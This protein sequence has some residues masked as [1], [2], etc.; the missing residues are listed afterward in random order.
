MDG[1]CAEMAAVQRHAQDVNLNARTSG[2]VTGAHVLARDDLKG[3]I[4]DQGHRDGR[5]AQ[6]PLVLLVHRECCNGYGEWLVKKSL[7]KHKWL[8]SGNHVARMLEN[9]IV[10]ITFTWTEPLAGQSL[11]YDKKE[12]LTW[13]DIS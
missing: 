13:N 12:T 2:A 11:K 3:T 7:N 10:L 4:K 5:E 8:S 6:K 1:L 9:P